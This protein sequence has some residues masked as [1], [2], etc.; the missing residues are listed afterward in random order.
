[1]IV[2]GT[3]TRAVESG[4]DEDKCETQAGTSTPADVCGN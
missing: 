2:A 4:L 3:E 1:M